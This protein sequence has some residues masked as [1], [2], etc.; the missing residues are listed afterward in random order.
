M[1]EYMWEK[2]GDESL[3]RNYALRSPSSCWPRWA[4]CVD[5]NRNFFNKLSLAIG[6]GSY[7]NVR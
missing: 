1:V 5:A 4:G 7:L 3:V 2:E 6:I